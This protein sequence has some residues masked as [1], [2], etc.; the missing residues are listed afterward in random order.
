MPSIFIWKMNN[1]QLHKSNTTKNIVRYYTGSNW[2]MEEEGEK[3]VS[4]QLLDQIIIPGF[5]DSVITYNIKYMPTNWIGSDLLEVSNVEF[6]KIKSDNYGTLVRIGEW[7]R[8][9]LNN[10]IIFE[11]NQLLK[12]IDVITRW[13]SDLRHSGYLENSNC[14]TNTTYKKESSLTNN[15]YNNHNKNKTNRVVTTMYPVLDMNP[16]HIAANFQEFLNKY[17]FPFPE[18]NKV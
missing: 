10:E 3:S 7:M 6:E 11:E 2:V 18:I 5:S 9:T 15:N 8:F 1:S 17:S 13:M 12:E 14:N 16:A 4:Y